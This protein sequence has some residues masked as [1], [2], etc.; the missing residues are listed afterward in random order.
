[1][2]LART[3]KAAARLSDQFRRGCPGKT[4]LTI[5]KGAPPAKQDRLIHHLLKDKTNNQT[6]VYDQPLPG[7]KEARLHYQVLATAEK[8]SLLRVVLETGRSHQIRAQMAAVGCPIYG[9][10]RYGTPSEPREWAENVGTTVPV[11]L[12]SHQLKL[13]HPTQKK[14]ITFK[15]P[16]PVEEYPWSLFEKDVAG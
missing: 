1:M 7:S 10:R 3:S 8:F 2:V 9:D 4:Y 11:A 15:S 13:E 6:A 14:T 12:W 5:V 16:P